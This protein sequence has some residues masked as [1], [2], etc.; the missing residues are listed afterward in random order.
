MRN[1]IPRSL[2][3]PVLIVLPLLL[4]AKKPSRIDQL[5]DEHAA[6]LGGEELIRSVQSIVSTSEIEM[7]STGLKGTMKTWSLRPCLSYTEIGLGLFT[8]KHGFDGEKAWMIGPNGQLQYQ[9]DEGSRSNQVTTCLLEGHGYLLDRHKVV[10]SHAGA[11]S[12]RGRT[13]EVLRLLPPGGSACRIYLDIST[14]LLLKLVVEDSDGAIEQLFSDYRPVDGLQLPF[15]TITRHLA[16][17]Q[18]IR[19]TTQSIALNREIDPAIFFPP[20]GRAEDYRFTRGRSS[21]RIPFTYHSQHIFLP[22]NIPGTMEEHLFMLDSGAGMSLIDSSLAAELGLELKGRIPAAGAGGMTTL[23]MTKLPG[24]SVPGIE[25]SGQTVMTGSIAGMVYR[26]AGI[27]TGGVLGYDFLSRFITKIDYSQSRISFYSPD[28]LI[29]PSA[30]EV[31]EAPLIY[32]IF[33][34]PGTLDGRHG[35]TFLLDTGAGSSILQRSF[36]EA[37]GIKPGEAAV[38]TSIIGAGGVENASLIKFNSFRLGDIILEEPVFMLPAGKSGI[39]ALEG[40]SGIVGNDILQ[41]F[42]VY[43]DYR[44]QQVILQRN[45]LF[46]KPF[47][48]DK[49]GLLLTCSSGGEIAVY[50]AIG[51]TPA[52][53]AGFRAGDIITA[54]A[55][56]KTA[57]C[58][59]LEEILEIFRGEEGAGIT[60]DFRRRGKKMSATV[61]LR[62]YI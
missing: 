9:E 45:D 39:G 48:T 42:T 58:A 7:T 56:K 3:I 51:G 41:K 25:F 60:V 33:S 53:E 59:M 40:I 19:I 29:P 36:A 31:I 21:A 22:V 11:D 17:N 24:F 15:H 44:K 50:Q 27:K 6:A 20:S 30:G 1:I 38:E 34:L 47:F 23:Y 35:G 8:V 10:I 43:L 13:C 2:L 49:C 54:V 18:E 26:F 52:A 14:Y 12:V 46:E 55:G 5:L 28:T 62:A 32:K 57:E 4:N 37:R 16:L 61:I